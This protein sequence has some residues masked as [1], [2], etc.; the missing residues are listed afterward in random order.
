MS[1]NVGSLDRIIRAVL[2]LVLLALPFA[3]GPFSMLWTV[4][5]IAL[6][7]LMLGVAAMRFCPLYSLIGIRTC[8]P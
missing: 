2:G 4:V 1:V 3:F 7:A 5:S 6:G 8:R